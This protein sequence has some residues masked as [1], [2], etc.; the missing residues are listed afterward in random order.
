MRRGDRW[1]LALVVCG[2]AAGV[3]AATLL[4][5]A[6]GT[7]RPRCVSVVR[8]GFVGGATFTYC[9]PRAAAFCRSKAGRAGD[10]AAAC[11]RNR[12]TTLT[13]GSGS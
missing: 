8:A 12:I 5:R 9:G 4:G 11:R 7:G 13:Q 10:A 2:V 6:S 1:F 3:P